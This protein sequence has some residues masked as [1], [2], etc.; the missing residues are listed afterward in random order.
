MLPSG[1]IICLAVCSFNVKVPVL[2]EAITVQLPNPSTAFNFFTITFLLAILLVAKESA[3]VRTTGRPSGIALTDKATTNKN[4]S[5]GAY[6]LKYNI[7]VI[8]IAITIKII[9]I[10][11]VNFSILIAS[12]VFVLSL[13]ITLLA[14]LPISVLIP[15]ATTIPTPLPLITLAPAKHI[16]ERSAN[17]MSSLNISSDFKEAIDSPVKKDSSHVKL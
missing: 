2:S 4:I 16:L 17:L 8:I 3:T 11:F 15:V 10:C 13:E 5:L 12:G 7:K 14:I 6:P 1:K 9:L